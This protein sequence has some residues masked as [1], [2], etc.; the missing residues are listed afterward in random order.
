MDKYRGSSKRE[1]NNKLFYTFYPVILASLIIMF[2]NLTPHTLINGAI[3]L[4]IV[5]WGYFMYTFKQADYEDLEE[6]FGKSKKIISGNRYDNNLINL[7]K[8][9]ENKNEID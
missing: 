6:S 7:L 9:K 5:L 1:I 4:I 8:D 2:F 3:L